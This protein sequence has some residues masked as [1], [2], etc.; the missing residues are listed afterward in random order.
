MKT[1]PLKAILI[2]TLL[3]LTTGSAVACDW[4]NNAFFVELNTT[5]KNSL[6]SKEL[7]SAIKN[8]HDFNKMRETAA[9][10]MGQQEVEQILPVEESAPKAAAN[11]AVAEPVG[12]FPEPLSGATFSSVITN[13]AS[14]SAGTTGFVTQDTKPTKRIRLE[15][16]EGEVYLGNGVMY[17]GFTINGTIPGPNIVVDEGDIVE[18]KI[19]NKGNI[20][21]G[22]SIHAAYTQTSKYVGKIAPGDSASVVFKAVQPGVFLYHCAPGGHAIPM[23]VIFGQYGMMTVRPKMKYKLEE[24]LG[25]K[26]DVEIFL[27]QHEYYASGKDAVTGQGQPMYTAFNGK[28]FRYVEEPIKAKPGDYVRINYMNIGPNLVSTFHIVG[29]LWDYVYWQG[30]PKNMMVGGQSVTSGPTDSWVIEFRIPDDE[31]AYTMLSHAVGST[32]RGAIGLIVAERGIT[33]DRTVDSQGI[34]HTK[35]ELSEIKSSALRMISPFAPGSED[36]DVPVKYDA[37]ADTVIVQIIGNSFYPKIIDI[38]PGTT[39]KWVNEDV[40]TY[41]SGEFS[42]LH[43]VVGLSGPTTFASPLLTHGESWTYT[44]NELGEYNYMCAPHPYMRGIVR[45]SESTG[46]GRLASSSSSAPAGLTILALLLAV[47]AVTFSAIN[48]IGPKNTTE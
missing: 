23:H 8:Q 33:S 13:R 26:P 15:L 25:R 12:I 41:L 1:I 14:I 32:D 29:I 2:F 27:N 30:N 37:T 22:A 47:V 21:H 18:F 35:E 38:K 17:Q 20:A 19:V 34:F 40:F 9:Q 44:F 16:Q 10:I 48:M 46:K 4:C 7:L 43:N 31:G 11:V 6:V 24:E 45:I 39:V 42:G 36:V 28:L 5:R 3:L